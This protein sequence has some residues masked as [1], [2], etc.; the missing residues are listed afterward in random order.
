MPNIF[1]N[2]PLN[3]SPQITILSYTVEMDD[4]YT[5]DNKN[6]DRRHIRTDEFIDKD[7][8]TARKMACDWFQKESKRLKAELEHNATDDS[9]HLG[10]MLYYN[11]KKNQPEEADE[12]AD[13]G[14][15]YLLDGED[16]P[17]TE[18][19]DRLNQE[20]F[21]LIAAGVEFDSIEVEMG[22]EMYFVP[23]GGLFEIGKK[24][25]RF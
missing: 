25:K 20:Y 2:K 19:L 6:I 13:V 4:V 1:H 3:K 17:Q 14:R 8:L 15:F 11:F 24:E 16:V 7:I 23:L 18:L 22:G 12:C 9:R 5:V 10:L 21:H